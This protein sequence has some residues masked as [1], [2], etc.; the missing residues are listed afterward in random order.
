M[1]GDKKCDNGNSQA[2][3][4]TEEKTSD[5]VAVPN[6]ADGGSTV[7]EI[8]PSDLY[9]QMTYD[10]VHFTLIDVRGL[11][12]YKVE[13]LAGAVLLPLEDINQADLDKMG[14]TKGENIVVYCNAGVR[15]AKAYL[16]LKSLG[17]TNV[18]S[19]TGGI[20][21]WNNEGFPTESD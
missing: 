1:A 16:V 9:S 7:F 5:D 14:I 3:P 13:H 2:S 19:M 21:E 10:G 20:V 17:Y 15:S 4:E 11:Y 18:K 6:E 8:S 12:E